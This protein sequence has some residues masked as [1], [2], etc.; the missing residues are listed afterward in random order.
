VLERRATENYMTDRAVKLL[1]GNAYRE[2]GPFETLRSASISWSKE[3]NWRIA[4]EMTKEELESTDLGPF[5][6]TL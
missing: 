6:S 2:L 3:E 5:L 4:K 1:K